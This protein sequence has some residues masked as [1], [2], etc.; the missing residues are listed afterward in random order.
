MLVCFYHCLVVSL[1]FH[2]LFAVHVRMLNVLN[3]DK[4][5]NIIKGDITFAAYYRNVDAFLRNVIFCDKSPECS[6]RLVT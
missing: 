1:E 6:T 5:I 3:K 2:L 4:S